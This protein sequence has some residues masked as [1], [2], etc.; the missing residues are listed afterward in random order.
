[1]VTLIQ[2][3]LANTSFKLFTLCKV[4]FKALLAN[5]FPS[6]DLGRVDSLRNSFVLQGLC[7]LARGRRGRWGK[8]GQ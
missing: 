3:V 7:L 8:K 2:I 4:V 6:L 5:T 1:M